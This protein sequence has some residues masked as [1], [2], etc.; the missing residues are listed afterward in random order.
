MKP[1]FLNRK[2]NELVNNSMTISQEGF[3]FELWAR[4]VKRQMIAAL[5]KR[6]SKTY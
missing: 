6:A 3:D 5:K 2:P 4:E 1:K